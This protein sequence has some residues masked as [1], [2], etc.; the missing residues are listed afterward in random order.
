MSPKYDNTSEGD[1][2]SFNVVAV[3]R[4]HDALEEDVREGSSLH[5]FLHLQ[6]SK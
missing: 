5:W 3:P 2:Y 6:M 4:L 1:G